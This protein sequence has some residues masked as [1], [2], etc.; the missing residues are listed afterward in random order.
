MSEEIKVKYND[1]YNKTDELQNQIRSINADMRSQYNQI[2]SQLN[3]LDSA[4]N[5]ALISAMERNMDKTDE[6]AQTLNKFL[7]LVR[8][9]TRQVEQTEWSISNVFRNIINRIRT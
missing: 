8:N 1:V 9:S 5:A 3:G 7:S 6:V 2:R 4:T